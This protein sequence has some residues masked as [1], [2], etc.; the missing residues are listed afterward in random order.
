LQFK[1]T[2]F[3][4]QLADLHTTAKSMV[5]SLAPHLLPSTVARLESLQPVVSEEAAKAA[6]ETAAAAGTLAEMPGESAAE[7]QARIQ[8][9]AQGATDISGLVKSRKKAPAVAQEAA[10]HANGNG[11]NGKRKLEDDDDVVS[12]KK[13]RFGE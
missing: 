6:A 1:S 9:A 12:E 10:V 4:S 13:V 5:P 7:R 3:S 8:K 11:V 2:N